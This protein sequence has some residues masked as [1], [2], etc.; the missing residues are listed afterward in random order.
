M[1]QAWKKRNVPFYDSEDLFFPKLLSFYMTAC[2]KKIRLRTKL[3]RT[4]YL[5][6]ASKPILLC[7][8]NL[9]NCQS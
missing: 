9:Q 2:K 6:S 7:N 8:C 3:E 4:F 5:L 1:L